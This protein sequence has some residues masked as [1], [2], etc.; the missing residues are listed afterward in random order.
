MVTSKSLDWQPEAIIAAL[1]GK[2]ITLTGLSKKAGYHRSAASVA[3][4]R[5]WPAVERLIASALHKKPPEIWPSRYDARG[6]PLREG[7][8]P[9]DS[10]GRHRGHVE[11][12]R[13]A[14]VAKRASQRSNLQPSIRGRS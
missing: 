3:L 12:N 13:A 10:T 7:R 4:R 1:H 5:S 8:W 6:R 11:S 14:C 9:H 2:Q